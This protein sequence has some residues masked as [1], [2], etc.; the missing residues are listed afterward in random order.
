MR[1]A[2]TN[3]ID[4]ASALTA[5]TS[6]SGYPASN[7]QDQRLGLK[8]KSS[9]A[10]SQ[11]VVVQFA[12]TTSNPF[13]VI[14]ICGHNLTSACTVTFEANS[15]DSWG[16]PAFTTSLTVLD[17]VIINYLASQQ[18]YMYGRFVFSGQ[19]SLEIGRL[20]L[21]NF[22]TIDPSSTLAFTVT[23]KRSDNVDYGKHRQKYST[24]GVGWRAVN[25]TF[26]PT[27]GTT[28]TNI[29]TVIDAV[30]RH[31]SFI[32]SNFDDIR[33]YPLVDPLYCSF[34]SDVTFNHT[35]GM[36]FGYPLSMEEDL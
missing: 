10:T 14:A 22:I 6:L 35:R 34:T 4:S 8:W 3:E 26:P 27:K 18:E 30:G 20:W 23:K 24:E 17:G 2:Y 25:L 13:Q 16:A 28:L 7:A 31:S 19:A 29:Q 9:T 21:S 12:S 32:F 36:K 1:I 11:N 33:T 15:E 5:S